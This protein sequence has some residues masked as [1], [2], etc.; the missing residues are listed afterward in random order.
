[1]PAANP[2]RTGRRTWTRR[3]DA[4]PAELQAA[5]LRLFARHGYGGATIERIAREAGVTVGTV[6]RY[7]RDKEALHRSIAEWIEREPLLDPEWTPAS[8]PADVAIRELLTAVWTSS[9]RAPHPEML[10]IV[11]AEDDPE[12]PLAASY[13]RR[14]IAPVE[15]VMLTLLGRE[16]DRA[17]AAA[18]AALG[19]L[20]GA[21]LLAGNPAGTEAVIPQ[22]A[23]REI[24]VAAVAAGLAAIPP[25]DPD[26]GLPAIAPRNFGPDAW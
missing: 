17:V 15:R 4:R 7:Y 22:L 21:S 19:S 13:R 1:M 8:G 16:D 5:A 18:R 23:P 3:S 10:R 24:T 9:R 2:N 6:Y 20:L 12:A 14:V 26:T 25:A 11:V